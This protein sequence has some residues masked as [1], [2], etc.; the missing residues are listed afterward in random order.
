MKL[1]TYGEIAAFLNVTPRTVR[2][3]VNKKAI[4]V[5][6]ISRRAVRFDPERVRLALNDQF[7]Q[8]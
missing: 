6:R 1:M 5:I 7:E 3:W 8:R 2:A 4:P